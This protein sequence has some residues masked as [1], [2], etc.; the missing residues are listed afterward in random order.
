MPLPDDGP[1]TVDL[2]KLQLQLTDQVDDAF[3][4]S[5]TEA[6]N[7]LVR[8]M[9]VAQLADDAGVWPAEWPADIVRGAVM[10]A[11]RLVRRRNSPSGVEAMTD[12]G[13]A[14]VSRN[15][16]DIAQLLQLGPYAKPSVG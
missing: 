15:D 7:A 9:R 14:Y 3:V 1:A 11:A 5:C 8:G 2:V 13:A 4:T 6:T 12:Q 16:P 10:L